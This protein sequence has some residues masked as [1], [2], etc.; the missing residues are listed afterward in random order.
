MESITE[1]LIN[2]GFK[3][4]KNFFEKYVQKIGDRFGYSIIYDKEQQAFLFIKYTRT[5]KY[6][7]EEEI[8]LN[9]NNL[10]SGI[11]EEWLR[12][13]KEL[14][15]FKIKFYSFDQGGK[16]M[17]KKESIKLAAVKIKQLEQK[18]KLKKGA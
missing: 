10:S 2:L 8:L 14:E 17:T 13:K 7:D 9:H 18:I 1:K 12:I 3:E 16:K 15:H 11:K 5:E 6:I 4:N